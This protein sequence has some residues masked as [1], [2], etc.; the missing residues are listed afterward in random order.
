MKIWV[1]GKRLARGLVPKSL[2]EYWV[3]R[4][5]RVR[6]E[7]NYSDWAAACA[8]CSGYDAPAITAK[9]LAAARLVRDGRATYERDGVAFYQPPPWW[10]GLAILQDAAQSRGGALTVLDFGGSLGSLYFQSR[11]QLKLSGPLRWRIVEQAALLKPGRDEFQT[12]ELSFHQ[13]IA[14][15]C[16]DGQPDV[17]LL[18][19]VLPYL[20]NQENIMQDLL[21]IGA[22]H[23]LVDRTGFVTEGRS[24][25]TVQRV[26]RS[27]YPASYPCW[28]LNRTE[29][30]STIGS[31]YRLAQEYRDPVE[32][33][34]GLEFRSIH[35]IRIT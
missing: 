12:E 9:V 19:S 35:F 28:F 2:F 17:I 1:A 18:S 32:T 33:P 3:R 29:F 4:F 30:M 31:A 26:P 8:E 21:G 23:V 11:A 25:L 15:A 34:A 20:T 13:S 16:K 22:R 24:R 10:P 7:G 5:F 6:W 27:I 14:E